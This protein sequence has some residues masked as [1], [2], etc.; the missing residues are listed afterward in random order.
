MKLVVIES[1]FRG[2]EEWTQD[3]NIKYAQAALR[4]CL[5]RG[6]APLASHLLYTQVLNDDMQEERE[7]GIKVGLEWA[8]RAHV[9]M[10]FYIDHGWSEGMLKA[11][12]YAML[13]SIPREKRSLMGRG[14]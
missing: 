5:T 14:R 1:P 8:R 4:H 9:T 3:Q 13:H 6:E 10:V 12:N 7:L 2:S 11:W